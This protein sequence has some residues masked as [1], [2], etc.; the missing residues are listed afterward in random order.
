MMNALSRN[1]L[2][3]LLLCAAAVAQDSSNQDFDPCTLTPAECWHDPLIPGTEW[4]AQ[5]GDG[6]TSKSCRSNIKNFA[7]T[8]SAPTILWA[9]TEIDSKFEEIGRVAHLADP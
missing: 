9:R 8:R 3:V 5:S 4:P 6:G 2:C 7:S 1:C